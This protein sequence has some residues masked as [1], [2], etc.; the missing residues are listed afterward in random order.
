MVYVWRD[1]Q[2]IGREQQQVMW[3]QQ[4]HCEKIV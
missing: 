4:M 2:D 1:G 3:T